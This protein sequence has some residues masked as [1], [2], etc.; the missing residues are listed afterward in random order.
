MVNYYKILKVNPNATDAEIK[1]AYRRLAR[2]M[3]P[4][5][6][7][8]SKEATREFAMIAKAYEVLSNKQE[9]AYYDRQLRKAQSAG[10]IHT[11]DS[12]FYSNNLYASQ[13]RQMAIERRYN[14]II[15]RMMEAERKETLALQRV[16]FPTVALFVSTCFVAI[17]KPLFWTNSEAIGK[18]ILLTLFIVSVFHL[19]KLIRYGFQHY[20]YTSENLHD[21]ILEKIQTESKPFSR[22]RA[23]SFLLIGVGISLVIGLIIGNFMQATIALLM[24]KLFSPTL[25]LEFIF[26]PPIFVLLVDVMHSFATKVD[27]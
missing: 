18:I 27:Y 20:T 23:A 22:V 5:V 15:D 17:F 21:S 10:S 3:H 12:V 7:N 26:Y 24:P 9:R 14:K 11:T 4:D 19:V 1:S 13:L 16:I 2:E 8:D 25:Q 6:N